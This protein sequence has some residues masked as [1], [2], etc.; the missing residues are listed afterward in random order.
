MVI[1]KCHP[2][3][4]RDCRADRII[5]FLRNRYDF[6]TGYSP[7]VPRMQLNEITPWL[8]GGL[9]YGFTKAWADALRSFKGGRLASQ[10]Y[11]E[12]AGTGTPPINMSVP[13]INNIGLPLAN[14]PPPA[15]QSLHIVNRFW[16]KLTV[17]LIHSTSLILVPPPPSARQY[18]IKNLSVVNCCYTSLSLLLPPCAGIGNPRGNENPF[19][20]TM[21]ILWFRVHNWWADRL[22]E[23]ND[24]YADN[25]EWL[26][27]R[28]RQLTI[29]THQHLVF[30]EWLPQ[31]IPR[32]MMEVN[33][34]V[35]DLHLASS[36]VSQT[37]TRIL[38][39]HVRA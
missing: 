30:S 17:A 37:T 33:R 3:F 1:P 27:N 32:K 6:N 18:S 39:H 38:R 4:D 12:E 8:D 19:L 36:P 15:N 11:N 13:V 34:Q 10:Y 29:A 21:G 2:L 20:L 14:P 28:A 23:S 24:V 7:N 5:P 35:R 25:D 26:Y 31:F 16:R 22:R 9:M